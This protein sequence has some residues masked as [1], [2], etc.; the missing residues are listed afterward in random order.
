MPALPVELPG[1]RRVEETRSRRRR[2]D[3][4][5][6]THERIPFLAEA[7]GPLP[8]PMT[9]EGDPVTGDGLNFYQFVIPMDRS[10]AYAPDEDQ[11]TTKPA[12]M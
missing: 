2:R 12:T 9:V 3:Q 10:A 4:G 5:T 1:A 11:P 7:P 8:Y 6:L